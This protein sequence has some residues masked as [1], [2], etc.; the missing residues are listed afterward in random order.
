MFNLWWFHMPAIMKG[1]VDRVYAYGFS[2]GRG[3]VTPGHF[4]DRYGEGVVAGKRCMVICLAGTSAEHYSP[5]AINGS[6]HDVRRHAAPCCFLAAARVLPIVGTMQAGASWDSVGVQMGSACKDSAVTG[7][8]VSV[9]RCP[10][11]RV[12]ARG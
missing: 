4:F 3:P 2:Y 11:D 8:C 6:I 7:C 12:L 9:T 1:W 10:C 5:R